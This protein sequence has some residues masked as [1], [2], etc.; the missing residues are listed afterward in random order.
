MKVWTRISEQIVA[1]WSPFSRGIRSRWSNVGGSLFGAAPAYENTEPDF[2]QLRTLYLNNGSET[3]G[4]FFAR[5][6]VD[7]QVDFIGLPVASTEDED[8]DDFLNAC[9]TDHWADELRQMFRNAIR[10][11]KTCVRVQQ[12]DARDNP[13]VSQDEIKHCRL[14]VV[15]PER[16]VNIRRATLDDRVIEEAVIRHT[17][18]IQEED[19]DF[20]NGILP[21]TREHEILEVITPDS[22]RYFDVTEHVEKT[23]WNQENLWGFVPVVEVE[24]DYDSTLK[25][26]QSDLETV[27]P[28]I[29]AFND[30]L[31][32]ALQAHKYHSIPKV[33]FKLNE[34]SAFIRNNFPDAVDENGNVKSGATVTWGGKEILFLQAE[35]DAEFLEARSV[36]GESKELLEFIID[37]I[38]I[39]SE[40]PRW[41]F[42]ILEAGSAN[43]SN[44][45]QT[46]PWAKKIVRKRT[47]YKETIQTLCKMVMKINN[48]EIVRPS[49][50]W[51]MIR[52]EDQAAHNQALQQLI[53]G[54]E[55]AA[56]RQIISDSTY[57]E[58]L[59]QFIPNM[60]N[61]TEEAADAKDNFE[62]APAEP[63]GNP[64][65][66]GSGDTKNVP[67]TAGK[68]GKNE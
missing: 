1:I 6:I 68:Q 12:D 18:E 47:Q 66:N 44:N 59:R 39:A 4:A 2:N 54:L 9:L 5:P 58:L 38:A 27:Y 53:M 15:D 45:A 32:Q 55:V 28:L 7:L 35:E 48:F 60:K 17:V 20:E 30:A 23:D 33:K 62:I 57:R 3:L 65:P 16:I 11:S 14:E 42:M 52:V 36:I 8:R 61:P 56:Q 29:R 34:I 50:S 46:L 22:Y 37:C 41:A 51:E 63:F 13:L 64:S 19:G 10:D 67:V 49:L 26:G 24:N 40:T 43:Q 31:K 25:G 21:K